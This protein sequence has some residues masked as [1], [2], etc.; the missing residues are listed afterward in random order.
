MYT[1]PNTNISEINDGPVNNLNSINIG[2]NDQNMSL[3]Q[4]SEEEIDKQ[5]EDVLRIIART[6]T[7]S[8]ETLN[9]ERCL[10][11][12]P[13]LKDIYKYIGDIILLSEAEE[14]NNPLE[15]CH[16]YN[17]LE[18]KCTQCLSATD[19]SF[20]FDKCDYC[21]RHTKLIEQADNARHRK[22]YRDQVANNVLISFECP[23]N[24]KSS[25]IAN[26][27]LNRQGNF[28]DRF[29]SVSFGVSN[30][31]NYNGIDQ[32]LLNNFGTLI[33][34]PSMECKGFIYAIEYLNKKPH[35]YGL[36]RYSGEN[37]KK[38]TCASDSKYHGKNKITTDGTLE[39]GSETIN[40]LLKPKNVKEWIDYMSDKA[41]IQGDIQEIVDGWGKAILNV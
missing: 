23:Q 29:L 8:D 7:Y 15:R 11:Y 22:F 34:I 3:D 13:F 17:R 1:Q 2:Y 26:N 5:L 4:L 41:E 10:M 35:L 6:F 9:I 37:L 18:V 27:V 39:I 36:I 31:E 21:K 24:Q 20:C 14:I 33:N 25:M 19:L 12:R 32:Q 38:R 30:K 40:M 16:I 28:V